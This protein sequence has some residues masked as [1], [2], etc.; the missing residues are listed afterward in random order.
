MKM[1]IAAISVAVGICAM[2]I[3]AQDDAP[4]GGGRRGPAH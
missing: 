1:R 4:T 2:F 3:F